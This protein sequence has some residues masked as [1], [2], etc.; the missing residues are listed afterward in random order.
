MKKLLFLFIFVVQSFA[1]LSVEE[2]TWDNGDTLLKFLQRNSIPMS[3]YYGLDKE[4]Q[5]LA[6]DIAY[7]IKYQVLKDENNNIEQVLIP[8][9]D[10]LQIHI[11][12]NKNGQYTLAFAPVSYEKENRI[13]H[14]TIKNSAYQ[15]VYEESGSSTL[16]RAMVR[17]F[18]GS[19][20]F[21]N[22]QKGDEVILYY[23]QK[24]RMGKLWGDINIKMAKV[25]I[26]K[27]PQEVFSYNDI[28]Y[29]RDGK[30][31]E[32]FLL[33]KPLNYTRISSHFTTAR[34]H[35]I[36]KRYRAHLG[37]DYVAPTG[38]PVKSAGKGVIT[39]VGTK[40]GYGNVI[41]IKHDSGY[42]TLYAHLSRFAK[43][44]NGQKVNQGQLIAYVGSTGMSTGP[45]LHF[46][47]YLNNK[48]INPASVV[49]IAKSE[50]NGKAKENFKHTIAGYEK[51]L[52]HALLSNQDNPP[53]ETEFENYIEF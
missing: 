32:S 36:L 9:S 12:K 10:D 39:F 37:I 8:I 17:A 15:D 52:K 19:I 46:G 48:A 4:D 3:L 42:M 11:Y 30:E 43:I 28:F 18:R 21:R 5:E 47:V 22:I 40:G 45:H 24:R 31:L 27:N 1:A 35:P 13:L 7:K 49:K 6:S 38:T 44:K 20:N 26:N 53:K 2:L 50:L 29:N 33:T 16:A 14:L 34:Y 41:Q 51:I 23:E 25:E